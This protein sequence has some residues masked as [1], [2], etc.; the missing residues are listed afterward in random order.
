M[1]RRRLPND[2][3][4]YYIGHAVETQE[5]GTGF[6]H[7]ITAH[8]TAQRWGPPSP[9]FHTG[10][11]KRPRSLARFFQHQGR[12]PSIYHFSP[13]IEFPLDAIFSIVLLDPHSPADTKVPLVR[14]GLET[15]LRYLTEAISRMG[16][17]QADLA[18]GHPP[19][20]SLFA[21]GLPPP[22]A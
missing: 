11:M 6:F 5:G 14:L 1:R 17:R 13:A 15:S 4:S 7:S 18:K 12:R 8:P 10:P 9:A 3:P 20:P 19:L 21:I 16:S 22:P 2:F